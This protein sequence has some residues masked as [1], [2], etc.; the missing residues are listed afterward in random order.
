MRSPVV[1]QVSSFAAAEAMRRSHEACI[2]EIQDLPASSL[3]IVQG[4]ELADGVATPVAHKLGRPPAW[5]QA[6]VVRGAASTGRIV[7]SRSGSYS[8]AEV[9]LLTATGFGATVTIDLCVL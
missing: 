1:P 5:T 6:S 4:V 9:V 7:E 8:R 2:R 3:R